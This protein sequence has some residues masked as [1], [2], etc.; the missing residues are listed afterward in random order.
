MPELPEVEAYRRRI[1]QGACH[2]TIAAVERG[3]DTS[4]VDLPGP[5]DRARL[6]GHQFTKARRHG[7]LLFA[8]SA[9]GPWVALHMGMAG[10][11]RVYDAD[12]GTPDYARLI[13]TFEGDRRMA[14][15]DP[16]KFGWVK[17]I[18]DPDAEIASHE[19]GPDVLE[20]DAE[21]FA[22]RLGSG[23][24]AVKSALT[25]QARLA[26]MGNLWADETLYQVGIHPAAKVCDL[27]ADDIRALYRTA[28]RILS[29]VCD[30]DADYAALPVAWLIHHREAGAACTRCDGTI[31]SRKIG[32]RT[33]FFCPEHQ[34]KP[35]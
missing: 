11:V 12:D 35:S 34:P 21:T 29:A 9:S 16:R 24:G 32:G 31:T 15:R 6:D 13:V 4:H 7:K 20:V 8:G 1:E 5:K 30:A 28:R 33:S 22:D 3:D 14:F 17:V 10:S 19:L 23:H 18:D 2:R 25:D 26:G 27:S